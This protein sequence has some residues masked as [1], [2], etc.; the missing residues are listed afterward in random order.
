MFRN[1]GSLSKI[2]N[3]LQ[4]I[5][6]FHR[7][8]STHNEKSANFEIKRI[9]GFSK[10]VKILPKNSKQFNICI[11]IFVLKADNIVVLVTNASIYVKSFCK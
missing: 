5:Y 6:N 9:L 7:L 2:R 10:S 8:L 1:V 3:T 4:D 11:K